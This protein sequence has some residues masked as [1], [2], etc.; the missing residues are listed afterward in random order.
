[1]LSVT[2]KYSFAPQNRPVTAALRR[3]GARVT[4]IE[5]NSDHP[6]ADHR[7]ALAQTVVGWLNR[8]R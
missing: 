5:M 4:A 2:A 8:L 7:I 6:F 3:A 1:V